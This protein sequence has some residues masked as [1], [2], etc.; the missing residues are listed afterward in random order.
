VNF[1]LRIRHAER[2]DN[3][4]INDRF[5]GIGRHKLENACQLL[6]AEDAA[7]NAGCGGCAFSVST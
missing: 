2:E 3:R 6:R 5:R 4:V 1:P 7:R